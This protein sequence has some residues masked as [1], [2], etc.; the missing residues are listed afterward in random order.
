MTKKRQN[1]KNNKGFAAVLVAILVVVALIAAL[2]F[3]PTSPFAGQIQRWITE[4]QQPAQDAVYPGNPANDERSDALQQWLETEQP[5][6]ATV[7]PPSFEPAAEPDDDDSEADVETDGNRMAEADGAAGA[8]AG[9]SSSSSTS[10]SSSSSSGSSSGGSTSG[11]SGSTSSVDGSGSSGSSG[12]SGTGSSSSGSTS[13]GS[14]G[15]SSPTPSTHTHTLA[16]RD[17]V[18]TSDWVEHVD[19]HYE[20]VHHA[21]VYNDWNEYI[22]VCNDC[23][24]ILHAGEAS[25]HLKASD[26]ACRSYHSETI[27]HHDLVSEAWD[28]EVWVEA[29][30]EVVGYKYTYYT[31]TY[32]TSCGEIISRVQS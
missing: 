17:V 1:T 10:G 25:A 12:N 7:E 29:H 3:I 27:Y 23:G 16:T 9:G 5:D 4:A 8:T 2:E 30:D 6:V 11:N 18:E 26:G 24:A 21:A 13:G 22:D 19:G 20:T 28:E 15:G 31:E 14:T 32:C